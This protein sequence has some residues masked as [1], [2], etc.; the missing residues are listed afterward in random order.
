MAVTFGPENP[1]VARGPQRTFFTPI[2]VSIGG[3]ADITPASQN[4]RL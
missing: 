2:N 4:V 3:K 1:L